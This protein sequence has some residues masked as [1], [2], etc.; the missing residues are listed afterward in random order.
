M[1]NK[2]FKC[3]GMPRGS[4][5]LNHLAFADDMIILCKVE[6]KTLKLVT[7]T[8]DKYEEVS[9]QK[10]NKE[11]SEIY[12]HKG[13]SNG[14]GIIAEIATG[15]MRRDFNFIYLGCPIFYMRKKKDY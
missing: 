7:D 12:L 2:D 15:I 5:K 14:V 9:G 4:P 11:K 10:I 13:V 8:L 1:Q 3:F 6:V